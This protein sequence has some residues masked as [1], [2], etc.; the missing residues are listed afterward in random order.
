VSEPIEIRR[1]LRPGD[2]GAIVAMH[3]RL[4]SA[5]YGVDS[6][7]EA[8]VASSIAKAGS[9]GFPGPSEGLWIVERDGEVGGSI[10]YT[11]EGAGV[12]MVR[13]VL[14]EPALRGMGLGRQL[15]GDLLTEVEVRGYSRVALETFSDLRAAA[16]LYR[17]HGLEVVWEETGPRWGRDVITY[18]RYE[19]ELPRIGSESSTRP[20]AVAAD[21][22][23]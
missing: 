16:H 3:G 4:Y 23:A 17:S 9:S 8:R 21:R 13:W 18:Q 19:L 5:E 2:L 15:L 22:S 20:L 1:D 6:S 7:F 14:L 12:A 10:A 11:D